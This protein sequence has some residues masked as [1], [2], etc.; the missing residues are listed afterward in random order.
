MRCSATESARTPASNSVHCSGIVFVMDFFVLGCEK[1]FVC[2]QTLADLAEIVSFVTW[3]I[4]HV[5]TTE[6]ESGFYR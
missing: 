5:A 4:H 1:V 2:L 6:M 3:H